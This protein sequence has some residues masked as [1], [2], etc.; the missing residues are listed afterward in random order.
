M[1]KYPVDSYHN[2]KAEFIKNCQKIFE[3]SYKF[4][5]KQK[6][7]KIPSIPYL[8]IFVIVSYIILVIA[9]GV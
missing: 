9:V 5:I 1:G 3:S 8:A 6:H 4:Y 7:T 2:Y